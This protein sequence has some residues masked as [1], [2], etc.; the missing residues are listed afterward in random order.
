MI[1]AHHCIRYGSCSYAFSTHVWAY[2]TI[3]RCWPGG[4]TAAD[5]DGDATALDLRASLS[6]G[7]C[8]I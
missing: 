6:A 7:S 4:R 2:T 8:D 5:L 3:D 1:R